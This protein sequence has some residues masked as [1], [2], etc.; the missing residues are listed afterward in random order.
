MKKLLALLATAALTAPAAWAVEIEG[1]VTL[2][3]DYSFRGWSQTD[4]DPA[5]QAG[6]D[7]TF[8]SGFYV[9]T[10]GSN[11]NDSFEWDAYFGWSGDVAE[12]VELDVSLIHYGYPGADFDS[13]FADFQEIAGKLT[14]S[15]FTVGV[16]YSWNLGDETYF[17]PFVD[18]S[19]DIKE[20][21]S[22][23]LHVGFNR[24]EDDDNNYI[25]YSAS[26]GFPLGGSTLSIGIYGA[27]ADDCDGNCKL[28]P[29]LS[30][31][32]QFLLSGR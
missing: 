21:V 13:G 30:L 12:D 2:T 31:S 26:V 6:L 7:F 19:Y 27:N 22:L 4:R 32:R 24:Y 14:F 17:Y 28:R 5:I 25:D 11:I 15:D 18:Y 23:D 1:N 8:E 20:D 29:I 9:G 16:N 3:S 10:W